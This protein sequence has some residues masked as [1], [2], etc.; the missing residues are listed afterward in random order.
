MRIHVIIE[1]KASPDMFG[2][3]GALAESYGLDAVWTANH[4]SAR[5]PFICFTGLARATSKIRLGPVAISPFEYHPLKMANLLFAL[6]ELSHGRTNIV[7]GGGGGTLDAMGKLPVRNMLK[8]VRE[9][10][11]ILKGVSPDKLLKYEGEIFRL[12]RYQPVWATDEP[13]LIYVAASRSKMLEL[14]AELADGLMMS[15]VTLPLADE[16]IKTVHE[17][18]AKHGRSPE[19]FHINNLY[20]WHVKKDKAEAIDEAKRKIWVRGILGRWYVE[21]FLS[22]QDCDLVVSKW[23]AFAQSYFANSPVVEGVSDEIMDALVDNITLTGDYN[24]VDKLIE[25]LKKFEAAG[26]TEFGLRLYED[27]AESIKLIGERVVPAF[28]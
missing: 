26:F 23:G 4:D 8:G 18:L 14:A 19:G 16:S 10:V 11:E 27:P 1:P 20:A 7:V 22:P 13:P 25:E 9:C 21:P 5:D 17:G 6:N 12:K 28:H 15:D 2:E 3:L 24:D